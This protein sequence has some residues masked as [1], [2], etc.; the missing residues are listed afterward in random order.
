MV[1]H[2]LSRPKAFSVLGFTQQPADLLQRKLSERMGA[3]AKIVDFGDRGR[4]FLYTSYGDVAETESAIA[5]KLGFVRSLTKSPLTSQQ[6]LEQSIITPHEIRFDAFR[7]NAL[8]ACLSK[9]EARCLALKNLMSS[10]QLYY[11]ISGEEWVGADNLHCLISMLDRV[12]LDQDI[13]P[14]HFLLRHAPGTLTCFRGVNRL[15][16]GQLFQWREGNLQ[17]RPVQDLRTENREPQFAR[18]D[19]DPVTHVYQEIRDVVGAYIDDFSQSGQGVG[20]LLSGGVDSS[21]ILLATKERIPSTPKSYSYAPL[22]TPSFEFEIGYAR[23][24]SRVLGTEHTFIEFTPQDYPNLIVRA[25]ELLGQP[26]LSDAEPCKLAVAEFL[27]RNVGD[28][29]YFFVAQGADTLFGQDIARKIKLLDMVRR[30][31]GSRSVLTAAGHLLKG[32]TG[33]GQVLLKGADIMAHYHDPDY[34]FAP[35][36][37]IAVWS[38]IDM[39]RRSFGDQVVRQVFTYRRELEEEYLHSTNHTE[40]VHVVELLSSTYEIQTQS[41]QLFL[42][43]D[44]EE[45]YPFMDDDIIRLSL[46]F[47]P[48][49]RYIRGL[50]VKPLLKDILERKGLSTIARRRKGG[51]TFTNDLYE[52]MRSGPLSEMVHAIARPGFLSKADMEQVMAHPDHTTWSL[53]TLDVFQNRFLRT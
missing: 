51:S 27:A 50:R 29:R 45:I 8:V 37:T 9:T 19:A 34:F 14:F 3:I 47:P 24:A 42:A 49:R 15:F 28:R 32:A 10:P 25:V 18:G 33:R 30:V 44:K 38:D 53:L 2:L 13:L 22:Q 6:L 46:A 7:G 17:V 40:R 23:Y 26:V 11:W 20:N 1:S 41:S 5:L 21:I 35:T 36:N 16:P 31:P 52:W 4:F 43:N 39:A 12:E 48:E